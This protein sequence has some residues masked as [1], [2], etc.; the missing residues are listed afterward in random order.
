MADA[1]LSDWTYDPDHA[2]LDAR[3][4]PRHPSIAPHWLRCV[5][6]NGVVRCRKSDG[7]AGEH[8]ARLP[9]PAPDGEA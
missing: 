7:H 8:V 5:W 9:G 4:Q 1:A 6:F 3:T 2:D